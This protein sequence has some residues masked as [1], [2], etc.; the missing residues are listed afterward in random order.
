MILTSLISSQTQTELDEEFA[1]RLMLEEREQQQAAWDAEQYEARQHEQRPQ[2]I[3]PR[4]TQQ[5]QSQGAPAAGTGDTMAE[6]QQQFN[7][8]AESELWSPVQGLIS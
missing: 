1:R 7:K 2:R 5:Q 4:P 6:L 3:S 8:I